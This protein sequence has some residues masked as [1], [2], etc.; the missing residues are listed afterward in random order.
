MSWYAVLALDD[1]YAETRSL[2]FPVDVGTWV[3]LAFVSLFAG[4]PTGGSPSATFDVGDAPAVA[5]E[6]WDVSLGV[7][8]DEA[9][10]LVLGTAAALGVLFVLVG[11]VMEFVLVDAVRSKSVRILGPFRR[12]LGAGARLFFFRTFVALGVALAAGGVALPVYLAVTGSN[13]WLLA[14]VV[15]VPVFLVALAV[16]AVVVEFTTAFAV[17]LMVEHD[18]GVLPAWR[19]LWPTLREE[20]TQ[21]AV[22]ALVKVVLLLGAGFLLGIVVTALLV[23]VGLLVGALAFAGALAAPV[24]TA[25]VAVAVV[26]LVVFAFASVPVVVG[27]RYHSLSTLDRSPA[28]FSLR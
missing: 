10:L 21:F 3:R 26:A 7:P 8:V 4:V 15:G 14:L 18:V 2:L 28:A 1:A 23:P 6:A 9:V 20:W 19:R 5:T 25:L 24:V 22:Y 11:S 17:P 12:R 13:A 16:A 27:L